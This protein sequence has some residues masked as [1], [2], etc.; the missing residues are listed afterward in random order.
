MRYCL[1]LNAKKPV[2]GV[3]ES[4][5]AFLFRYCASDSVFP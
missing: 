2:L 3:K 4:I 5:G 1:P